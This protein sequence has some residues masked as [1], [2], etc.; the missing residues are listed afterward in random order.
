VKN[1][2]SLQNKNI[3]ITGASS[4]IGRACAVLCSEMGAKILLIGRKVEEL[5]KT[6]AVL[7][8]PESATIL[9]LDLTH[10]EEVT[11]QLQKILPGFG[12]VDGVVHAA[13]ISTTLPFRN[14]SV[15]KMNNFCQV[16]VIASLHLTQLLIKPRNISPEGASII[17][18]TSVMSQV[19]ESA[20]VLYSMSKGALLAAARSMAIELAPK[21]IRINCIAPGVVETS[22]T[23]NA[24]YSKN[25]ESRERIKSLH[26]LGLGEPGDVAKACL[27]LLSETGKWVTGT[28][29]MIDGGYTAR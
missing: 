10:F 4:G 20:K 24:Y 15:E 9:S 18:I 8:N 5:Q 3:I 2:L 16:N 11:E 13:G 27:F 19:G 6:K 1:Y 14:I 29:L 22:M 12:K 23:Q 21:K 25:E 7:A 26:P 28:Q 17:F